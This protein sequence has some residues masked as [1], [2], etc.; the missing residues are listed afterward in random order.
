MDSEEDRN[1][2]REVQEES[3]KMYEA[4]KEELWKRKKEEQ[5]ERYRTLHVEQLEI[6]EWKRRFRVGNDEAD[7]KYNAELEELRMKRLR[8]N[9]FK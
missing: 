6:N 8:M 4:A 3:W 7:K 1:V 9:L 5:D 2:R